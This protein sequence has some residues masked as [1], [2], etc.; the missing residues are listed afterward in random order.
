MPG[1]QTMEP[2]SSEV[3]QQAIDALLT[4]TGKSADDLRRFHDTVSRAHLTTLPPLPR[5]TV[6]TTTR[7]IEHLREVDEALRE[8]LIGLGLVGG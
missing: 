6:A 5:A 8:V 4:V 7:I 3:V 2:T 1:E